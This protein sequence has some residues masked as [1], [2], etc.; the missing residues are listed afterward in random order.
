[1]RI[2]QVKPDY[3]RD[4]LIASLP[5]SVSRFYIGLWQEAD[6]A[7]WLRWN[8]P[9]IG[10]DLYGYQSRARRERWVK[11]RGEA[12]AAVGR[13][14]FFDCGHAYIPNLTRHQKFGGK[15]YEGVRIAHDRNCSRSIADDRLGKVG[16]GTERKG[17]AHAREGDKS[18]PT[19][20]PTNRSHLELVDGK[21][22]ERAS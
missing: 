17:S 13:L 18:P 7:G 21:W 22:Q 15:P 19:D 9:E 20:Q 12:L 6:D 1:M 10:H 8:V 11:E 3:W 14:H 16:K 5:D 2:R 4:E